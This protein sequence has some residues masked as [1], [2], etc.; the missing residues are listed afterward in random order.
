MSNNIRIRTCSCG[1]W[2]KCCVHTYVRIGLTCMRVCVCMCV[3]CVVCVC[4][5]YLVHIVLCISC[6]TGRYSDEYEEDDLLGAGTSACTI[7]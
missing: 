2:A 4:V 6:V 1:V 7:Y 3:V 5:V